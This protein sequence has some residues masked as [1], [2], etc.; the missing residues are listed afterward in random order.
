M[1]HQPTRLI[2][3]AARSRMQADWEQA[4]RG[5]IRR[6]GRPSW[7]HRQLGRLLFRTGRA[8]VRTGKQLSCGEARALAGARGR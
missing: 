7:A 3:M 8:L 1:S 6:F 4:A 2:V 5:R